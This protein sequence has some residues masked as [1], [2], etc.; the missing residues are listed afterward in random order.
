M[1]KKIVGTLLPFESL[2]SKK[3]PGNLFKS[4]KLFIDW[5]EKTGQSAWQMLPLSVSGDGRSPYFSYGIGLNPQFLPKSER[6]G[7]YPTATKKVVPDFYCEFL[8][9]RDKFGTDHWTKWPKDTKKI[10]PNPE[11]VKF[12]HDQQA[13]IFNKFLEIRNYAAD[14]GVELWG[15]IPF[16]LPINSPLVW[17]YPKA[18]LLGDGDILP[19]VAGSYGDTHFI[20][21]QT[22]GFPLYQFEQPANLALIKKVWQTRLEALTPILNK[23]RLDAAI[24]FF[25]YE[26]L[27]PLNEANDQRGVGPGEKFLAALE[28]FSRKRGTDLFVED[29]SG[30]NMEALYRACTKLKISTVSVF[31]MILAPGKNKIVK[32]DFDLKFS[33]N[34][35]YYTSTHDT[36]PLVS[37]LESLNPEQKDALVKIFM[38]EKTTALN[39]R[40]ALEEKAD[41]LIVAMQDWLLTKDRI[42]IPGTIRPQNW[43]YKMTV[44]IEDLPDVGKS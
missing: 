19:F 15:D 5:L 38:V 35:I 16:Y 22:W 6:F 29:I 3:Y 4:A 23:I 27:D 21:R 8:G 26:K 41:M 37:Y 40:H 10:A 24:R 33:T 30:L 1:T 32:S 9:L 43:Q 42:N 18:F 44:P 11:S 13:F 7:P 2:I 34:Q 31:T 25:T 14:H 36:L 17:H 12:Y 20:N 39:F 28:G